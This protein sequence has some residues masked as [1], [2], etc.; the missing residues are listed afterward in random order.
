[1][2]DQEYDLWLTSTCIAAIGD[3]GSGKTALCMSLLDRITDRPVHIYD[4]P[5]PRL[6]ESHG[7]LNMHRLEELYSIDNAV[8][9]IDEPQL[10]IPK[11]DKR[12]N[13]GL[14]KLL[15]IARHRDITLVLST[16]DTRWITRA[17]ESY[18]DTWLIKDLEPRLVKQGAL[19]KKVIA[20][21]VVADPDE[22][23]LEPWEYLFYNRH[24]PE[25]DGKH[26]FKRPEW[27]TEE[28][29]KP[30]ALRDLSDPNASG[31]VATKPRE[32]VDAT[33]N[34]RKG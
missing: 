2:N 16:V 31:K 21:Y 12:A 11:L 25:L 33:T 20:K 4:H 14:Q 19:A 23:A 15:S 10:S 17:L 29:S 30:Y 6:I 34:G 5:K 22:F 24:F 9:Y 8:C 32:K 3:R 18:V 28:W 1:M 13:E 27:F 7:W 26:V